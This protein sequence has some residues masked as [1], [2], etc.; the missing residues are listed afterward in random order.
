MDRGLTL[1]QVF[2]TDTGL[3]RIPQPYDGGADVILATS[4]ERRPTSATG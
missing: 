2:V 4:D 1:G 3:R